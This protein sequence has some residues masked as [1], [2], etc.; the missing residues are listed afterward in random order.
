MSCISSFT[1]N[2]GVSKIVSVRKKSNICL[3]IE[4]ELFF[5]DKGKPACLAKQVRDFLLLFFFNFIH[6]NI[7]IKSFDQDC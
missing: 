3:V 5:E 4:F 1:R 2:H 6:F 7:L